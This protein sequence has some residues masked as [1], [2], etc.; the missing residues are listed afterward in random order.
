MTET[1]TTE[2]NTSCINVRCVSFN[3]NGLKSIMSK[4]K[5]GHKLT[6][7]GQEN[8]LQELLR[9]ERPHILCLQEIRCSSDMKFE[10]SGYPYVYTLHSKKKGYAGVMCVS[11]TQANKVIY[12]LKDLSETDKIK[13]D[14]ARVITLEFNN[15]FLI[16][17]YCPNSGGDKLEYRVKVWEPA[18]RKHISELQKVKPVIACGDY[19]VIASD[20][21]KSKSM[22]GCAG[23]QL[24]EKEAFY[25][26]L[27]DA[28]N[29]R[30]L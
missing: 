1:K 21:D 3:C 18:F 14:E 10:Y 9:V 6:H 22:S 27:V 11:T 30:Q 2:T 16:N 20:W 13:D 4:S 19:N 7:S 25:Q 26:L 8:V 23:D 12:G 5:N 24:E 15:F 17:V 28:S 29:G